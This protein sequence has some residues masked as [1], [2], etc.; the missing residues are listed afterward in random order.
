VII[1]MTIWERLDIKPPQKITCR[2]CS[3]VMPNPIAQLSDAD[4]IPHNGGMTNAVSSPMC[5]PCLTHKLRVIGKLESWKRKGRLNKM[6][7]VKMQHEDEIHSRH[8]TN[9]DTFLEPAKK[10]GSAIEVK[11]KPNDKMTLGSFL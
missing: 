11:N 3:R 1:N 9:P 8:R 2:L 6:K 4:L 10:I 7:R 5:A